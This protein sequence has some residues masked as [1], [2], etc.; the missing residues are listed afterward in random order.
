M[1]LMFHVNILRLVQHYFPV[2]EHRTLFAALAAVLLY[3]FLLLP[4]VF[5]T[6]LF[7]FVIRWPKNIGRN[8]R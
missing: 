3:W 1:F 4:T 8:V 5:F 2:V 7:P 6:K